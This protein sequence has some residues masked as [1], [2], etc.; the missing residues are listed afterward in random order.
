MNIKDINWDEVFSKDFWFGIDRFSI[1]F[2][3]KMFL[4]IGIALV[5]AGILKLLYARFS[6]NKFLARVA[7]RVGK[8]LITIGLLEG[9]WYLLRTQ[10]VQALGTRAV[11][12]LL[13]VWLVIW[14]YFPLRY[15]LKNYKEDM[16][17][18]QREA[19][20]EKYLKK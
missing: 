11:A 20:R 16:E 19:S 1:H 10:F 14:L 5:V 18:A 9:L 4:Y 2:S 8:I 7:S 3:D 15:L 17:Q 13:L 12:M 6:H